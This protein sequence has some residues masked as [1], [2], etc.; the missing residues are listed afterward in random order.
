MSRILLFSDTHGRIP[1]MLRI[2]L[3]VQR[4][5]GVRID[6]IL[7]AG[8]LGVWPV[9]ERLDSATRRFAQVDPS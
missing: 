3:E 4:R 7:V 9:D 6:G 8:D 1:L 5:G 2:A